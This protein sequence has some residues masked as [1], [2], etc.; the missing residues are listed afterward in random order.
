MVVLQ[1]LISERAKNDL[2]TYVTVNPRAGGISINELATGLFE[3]M[4]VV[5]NYRLD[6]LIPV[7]F[8]EVRN[9][10][11]MNVEKI[12]PYVGKNNIGVI[13][14]PYGVKAYT[15]DLLT[16]ENDNG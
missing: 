15:N 3:S 6:R 16:K 12:M 7:D 2:P 14:N 10:T 5:D 1:D 9:E 8:H 4:L 11:M 13:N